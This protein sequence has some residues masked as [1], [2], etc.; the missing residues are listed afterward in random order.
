[1]GVSTYLPTLQITADAARRG[2]RLASRWIEERKHADQR[3]DDAA[4]CDFREARGAQCDE[5][6]GARLE[7][8]RENEAIEER[9]QD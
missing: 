2:W 3:D 1:M 7:S 5:R 6:V 4:E 9:E 8:R